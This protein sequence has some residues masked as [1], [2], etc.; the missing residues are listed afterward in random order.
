MSATTQ[1]ARMANPY[2]RRAPPV[3]PP[4]AQNPTMGRQSQQRINQN[5]RKYKLC[6]DNNSK[7]KKGQQLTLLGG[8]AFEA[9]KDCIV[10]KARFLATFIE[11]YRVP[12]RPHH[13]LCILNTKTKGQGELSAMQ[14]VTLDDNKRYKELVAP[15]TLA[16]KGSSRNLPADGGSSFFAPRGTLKKAPTP[17]TDSA[18]EPE[19]MTAGFFCEAVTKLVAD[20]TFANKHKDKKAPLAMMAFANAVADNIIRTKRTAE[21]FKQLIMEVPDCEEACHHPQYHSIVGQ[22]LLLVDWQ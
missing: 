15:I 16:E 5:K 7:R 10:C 17:T 19:Y 2:A 14:Q 9:K 21:F 22:K 13:P 1:T 3:A 18:N 4:V 6:G 12:K 20:E 8:V 11:G